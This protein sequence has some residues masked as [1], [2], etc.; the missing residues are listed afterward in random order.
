MPSPVSSAFAMM[1]PHGKLLPCIEFLEGGL[2]TLKRTPYHRVL[3][4]TFLHQTLDM[5]AWIIEFHQ[6]A[7]SARRKI[8]AIYL[9]MNGFS[10]NTSGWH[11]DMFGYKKAGE[12]WDL[13]WLA[14]WDTEPSGRFPLTGMETVQKAFEVLYRDP[15]QPLGVKMAG[16]VAGHLVTARFMELVAAAHA[17]ASKRYSKLRGL[18]ILATAHD[19]D[20]AHQSE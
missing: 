3:G 17:V 15:A 14:D 19:W 4:K 11:C 13:D 8:A 9:E 7:T 1:V 16:D 2:R 6:K 12:L 18:P 20:D 10:I 5:A